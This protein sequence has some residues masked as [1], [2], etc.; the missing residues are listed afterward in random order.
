MAVLVCHFV[1]C[2]D[3]CL[4]FVDIHWVLFYHFVVVVAVVVVAAY[5]DTKE[6]P[7]VRVQTKGLLEFCTISFHD[8]AKKLHT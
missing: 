2:L 4:N 5:F 7:P 1:Q 6:D 3:D 8:C